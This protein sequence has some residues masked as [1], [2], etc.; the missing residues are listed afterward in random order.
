MKRDATGCLCD[1]R[2]RVVDM[3]FDSSILEFSNATKQVGILLD[4]LVTAFAPYAL[5]LKLGVN[6]F[7]KSCLVHDVCRGRLTGQME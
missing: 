7:A 5:W 6:N 2:D 3:E 4:Q 1:W